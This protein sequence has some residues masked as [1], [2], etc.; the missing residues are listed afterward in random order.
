MSAF[1]NMGGYALWV[2]SAYAVVA[3]GLIGLLVD[4]RLRAAK[5]RRMVED[6]RPQR[7]AQAP[8]T[9]PPAATGTPLDTSNQQPEGSS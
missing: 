2:W 7:P 1:F 8:A 3:I 5:A 9:A 4:T 6:L